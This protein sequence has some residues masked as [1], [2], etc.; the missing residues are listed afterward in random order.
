L[1]KILWVCWKNYWQKAGSV[2]KTVEPNVVHVGKKMKK[3]LDSWKAV[4]TASGLLKKLLNEL[5]L[6][7]KSIFEQ[8]RSVEKNSKQLVVS[9]KTIGKTLGRFKNWLK[10]FG[11]VEKA[12][13]KT[14]GLL[15]NWLKELRVFWKMLKSLWACWKLCGHNC[16][17]ENVLG[18]LEKQSKTLLRSFGKQLKALRI[19]WKMLKHF[20][21]VEKRLKQLWVWWKDGWKSFGSVKNKWKSVGSLL[22]KL[23]VCWKNCWNNFGSVEKRLK[24]LWVCWTNIETALIRLRNLLEN[25]CFF[26]YWKR[27]RSVGKAAENTFGLLRSCWKH[28]GAVEFE[29][30]EKA[31]E[32]SAGLLKKLLKTLRV[33]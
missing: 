13:G 29:A 3:R 12:V 17:F 5:W 23:W 27:F 14:L 28:F 25:L 11:P 20:G 26:E 7:W 6:C 21:A 30:V 9:W 33:C 31:V 1:L 10:H 19:C 32:K 22:K 2:E 15:T 16:F 24:E 8:I 4:I 18:L